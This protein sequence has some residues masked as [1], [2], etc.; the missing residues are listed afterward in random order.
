MNTIDKIKLAYKGLKTHKVRTFLTLL[1]IIISIAAVYTFMLLGDGLKNIVEDRVLSFGTDVIRITSATGPTMDTL[2]FTESDLKKIEKIEGIKKVI[3]VK[4]SQ[5]QVDYN[6]QKLTRSIYGYDFNDLE[7]LFNKLNI[8]F[9]S[10]KFPKNNEKNKIIVGNRIAKTAFFKEL[11]V[12]DKVIIEEN[13]FLVSGVLKGGSQFLENAIVM[14]RDKLHE[15]TNSK[16]YSLIIAIYDTDYDV[17]EIKDKIT[18]ELEKKYS[19]KAFVVLTPTDLIKTINSIL[20]SITTFIILIAAVSLIISSIGIANTMY[21]AVLQRT[22][23]IG[24]MKATG[25]KN[26]DIK[27]MFMIESGILGFIGGSIG[28]ILAIIISHATQEITKNFLNMAIFLIK[29]KPLEAIILIIFSTFI[30]MIAGYAP[31]KKASEVNPIE[32]LRYE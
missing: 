31:A 3:G 24:I 12:K 8:Q 15:L 28:I 2:S 4:F 11:K 13:Q 22:K 32:A 6:G 18:S 30:G 7:Y 16:D 29:V 10:G 26:S 14:N 17:N 1:G 23:E 5:L 25:A 21:T 27:Y 19:K 9:S 20:G